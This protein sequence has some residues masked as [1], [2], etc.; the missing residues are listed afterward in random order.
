M[1]ERDCPE[2]GRRTVNTDRVTVHTYPQIN[3]LLLSVSGIPTDHL[4]DSRF[5]TLCSWFS[6]ST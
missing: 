6:F 1:T 5:D 4:A 3:L 2:L